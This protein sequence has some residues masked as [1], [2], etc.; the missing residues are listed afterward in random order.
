M[1]KAY[2]FRIYPNKNQEV[3]LNRTLATC[4]KLSG[5]AGCAET[6]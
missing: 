3:K 6:T 1:K 5:I 4:R 2:S